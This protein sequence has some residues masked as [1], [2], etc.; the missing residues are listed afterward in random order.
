MRNIG[1]I[2]TGDGEPNS[3][4][5]FTLYCCALM[6]EPNPSDGDLGCPKTSMSV[7]R[8]FPFYVPEKHLLA[9]VCLPWARDVIDKQMS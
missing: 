2:R 9:F 3:Y 6:V 8:F 5:V 7:A 4:C 1:T